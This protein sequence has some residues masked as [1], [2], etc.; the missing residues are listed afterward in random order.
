MPFSFLFGT[1][2][3]RSESMNILYFST[4]LPGGGYITFFLSLFLL[5]YSMGHKPKKKIT[6]KLNGGRKHPNIIINNLHHL[7]G[8]V[9]KKTQ[10]H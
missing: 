9:Y 6:L 2:K 1:T 4:F 8:R 5:W 7:R 10:F 3:K